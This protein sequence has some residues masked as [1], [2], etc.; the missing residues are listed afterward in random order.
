MEEAAQN[1]PTPTSNALAPNTFLPSLKPGFGDTSTSDGSEGEVRSDLFGFN[2]KRPRQMKDEESVSLLAVAPS[3]CVMRPTDLR[4]ALCALHSALCPAPQRPTVPPTATTHWRCFFR[5]ALTLASSG[6]HMRCASQRCSDATRR[7][8]PDD[9]GNTAG[10]ES[11][12]SVL[13]LVT[14]LIF[15]FRQSSV[16]GK[17]T[18]NARLCRQK[19]PRHP[20]APTAEAWGRR[21]CLV[22][23]ARR[24]R[25]CL[26]ANCPHTLA[27]RLP[28]LGCSLATSQSHPRSL[29][30]FTVSLA[31]ACAKTLFGEA[32]RLCG[33][34][35]LTACLL[36]SGL[37][38]KLEL[39]LSL[40]APR[41][42]P[43][44]L[45]VAEL[46]SGIASGPSR[47]TTKC[48]CTLALSSSLSLSLPA[49]PSFADTEPAHTARTSAPPRCCLCWTAVF[50]S[51]SLPPSLLLHLSAVYR[52]PCFGHLRSSGALVLGRRH[53]TR[54]ASLPRCHGACSR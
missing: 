18:I 49:L 24:T 35:A 13:K 43:P 6:P 37:S 20:R 47:R 7:A 5:L 14:R 45:G 28:R 16:G 53:H 38:L 51:S 12:R 39:F 42:R 32:L 46:P 26:L 19:D 48:N 21:A 33:R 3:A 27:R 2:A 36:R 4:S 29:G 31:S 25:L 30:H 9:R 41:P 52:R 1:R 40:A 23:I 17:G 22:H 50:S 15:D 54:F 11:N 10:F 8:W 34:R 44:W